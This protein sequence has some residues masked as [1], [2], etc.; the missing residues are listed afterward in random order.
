M[1]L[2][3][4]GGNHSVI[5][6]RCFNVEVHLFSVHSPLGQVRGTCV[7][8]LLAPITT[9]SLVM[10]HRKAEKRPRLRRDTATW[11]NACSEHTCTGSSV[12]ALA[13]ALSNDGRRDDD[14][15]SR[16]SNCWPM[17]QEDSC[18]GSRSTSVLKLAY[19]STTKFSEMFEISE[20]SSLASSLSWML[21][22]GVMPSSPVSVSTDGERWAE[23][24][25]LPFWGC[26]D[27]QTSDD[28]ASLGS[29]LV[30]KSPT[31][32]GSW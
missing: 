4:Q 20:R 7:F 9:A 5:P 12:G 14:C 1:Q 25:L 6:R 11:R 32:S 13:C 2:S 26:S 27:W 3:S 16:V 19:F 21:L 24:F 15:I 31:S 29:G 30:A 17:L 8:A 10:Q 22:G 23:N 18:F 28:L